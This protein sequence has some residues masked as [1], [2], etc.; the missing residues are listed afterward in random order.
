M[1]LMA[2]REDA[3]KNF[4]ASPVG[5]V[6]QSCPG[7]YNFK[8]TTVRFMGAV[9]IWYARI[10][11]SG[12][13]LKPA[14]SDK[15]KDHFSPPEERPPAGTAHWSKPINQTEPDWSWPAAYLRTGATGASTPKLVASFAETSNKSVSVDI[16]AMGPEGIRLEAKT[17]TLNGGEAKDVE[18]EI[19]GFPASVKRLDGVELTWNFQVRGAPA[20]SPDRTKHT[21]FVLDE[22][23]KKFRDRVSIGGHLWDVFEWSCG[24]AKSKAGHKDVLDAIWSHFT[25]VKASHDTGL[26]YW[27]NWNH[28]TAPVDPNQDLVSAIQSKDDPVE[29]RRN[30]ASCIVFDRVL[31]NCLGIQGIDSAEIMIEPKRE[32][33]IRAGKEYFP[34]QWNAT[35]TNGQGNPDAPPGWGNH[36]IADVRDPAGTWMIRDPSYGA[37]PVTCEEPV[38]GSSV[39]VLSYEPLTVKT[40][41]CR[42]VIISPEGKPVLAGPPTNFPASKDP[43]VP[44]HLIG[45]V[46]WSSL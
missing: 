16:S 30:A 42:E 12:S 31:I 3:N 34:V 25:P 29:E 24:W 19:Q 28:P 22:K 1:E 10:P 43:A 2:A 5:A 7:R 11:D 9:G 6:L 36:W 41:A 14:A 4:S 21:L 33:F 20:C 27:K 40:F 15:P 26:V 44:P 37:G 17:V 23:P 38:A 45:N 46:L 39:N 35:S 18:F 8:V 32:P 13:Y